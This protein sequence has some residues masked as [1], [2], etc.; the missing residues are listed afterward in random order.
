MKA[1]ADFTK[2]ASEAGKDLCGTITKVMKVMVD[3]AKR[4]ILA[5]AKIA[6][7]Q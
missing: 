3:E 5:Q 2:S 1:E 4:E 7:N 6:K